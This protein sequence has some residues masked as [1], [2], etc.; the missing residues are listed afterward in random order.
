MICPRKLC[1][2]PAF[3]KSLKLKVCCNYKSAREC[4]PGS[5]RL[6][7]GR[8]PGPAWAR[9]AFKTSVRDVVGG[10]Q[11]GRCATVYRT[12]K[13]RSRQSLKTLI[14]Y[15]SAPPLA[16]LSRLTSIYLSFTSTELLRFLFKHFQMVQSR[17]QAQRAKRAFFTRRQGLIRKLHEMNT[18]T[19]AKVA[20]VGIYKGST[21][22]YEE[23]NEGLLS[24]FGI[25][26]NFSHRLGPDD[27]ELVSQR[28]RS[29][30]QRQRQQ[31]KSKLTSKD[32]NYQSSLSTACETPFIPKTPK[33]LET[34]F[35]DM[36][37][38]PLPGEE[39]IADGSK[40]VG[41]HP[42][43]VIHRLQKDGIAPPDVDFFGC[44]ER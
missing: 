8:Y 36:C 35:D 40:T 6:Y 1:G 42:L 29:S 16:V 37:F 27:V 22:C 5:G 23:D 43:R 25:L 13:N 38:L 32:P 44:H 30:Q 26:E 19:E 3:R 7:V 17:S 2:L 20:L 34:P 11:M 28:K 4:K 10:G 9:A 21:W 33:D 24:R 12:A 14:S 15:F 41:P 31:N 18:L 39:T